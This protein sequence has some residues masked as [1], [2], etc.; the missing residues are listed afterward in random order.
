MELIVHEVCTL[1]S[2]SLTLTCIV[3]FLQTHL[4]VPQRRPLRAIRHALR[5]LDPDWLVLADD[6]TFVNYPV[7]NAFIAHFEAAVA[8]GSVPTH[9]PRLVRD[10]VRRA[11]LSHVAGRPWVVCEL[12]R[13]VM[14]GGAGYLLP[15]SSLG[16]LLDARIA[17]RG[18]DVL[19]GGLYDELRN[20][21]GPA[22]GR[23]CVIGEASETGSA[24]LP[25]PLIDLCTGY[26]SGERTCY[27]RW[28]YGCT[29]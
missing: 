19:S 27:H 23:V 1:I 14:S 21:T 8:L 12:V 3:I 15:R 9:T 25:M 13:H 17:V 2:V 11:L 10:L 20:V 7:L 24:S 5:L 18:Q 22:C 28:E 4:I 6:D 16:R 26:L 29:G